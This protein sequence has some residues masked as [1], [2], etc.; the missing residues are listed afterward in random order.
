MRYKLYKELDDLDTVSHVLQGRGIKDID[1][2]LK[3]DFNKINHWT[4]LGEDK[5][6]QAVEMVDNLIQNQQRILV[7]V[8]C[9][10][11]GYTSAAMF[12]NYI[13]EINKSYAKENIDFF[14]HG[15]KEH[16]LK[17]LLDNRTDLEQ[18]A[19]I[20]VPDAGSNDFEE[21]EFLNNK[22]I[23]V[24]ILD[25]HECSE[26]K[27]ISKYENIIF[28]NNQTCDYPNKDFS[29][30]GIVWQF[31]RA[32]DEIKGYN[33]SQQFLDLCAIA[34]LGDMMDYRSLETRMVILA[35]LRS[36][37]N[38]FLLYMELKNHFSMEKMGGTNYLSCAFYIVPFIN[39]TVRSGTQEEKEMI[40]KSFLTLYAFEKIPSNKRGHKGEMVP[41]VEEAVRVCGNIK[42]RQ[43]KLQDEGMKRLE[44]YIASDNMLNNS[45][46]VFTCEPGEVEKSIAGLVANKLMS[47]YQRPCFVLTKSKSKNDKEYYYRG[48]ARNYSLSE[49]EDLRQDCLNSGLVEYAAGHASAFGISVAEKDINNFVDYFNKCYNVDS[50]PVYWVDYIWNMESIDKQAIL[51]IADMQFCWGQEIQESMVAV[52]NID[53]SQCNIKLLSP[54]KHPT[55]KISLQDGVDFIKFNSSEEEYESFLESSQYL[56]IVGKCKKNEW[57]NIIT[58]QIQIEDY[59]LEH[60][61]VF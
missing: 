13:A 22:G 34:N 9:D 43:T 47:K 17:D 37:S 18:Y 50:E 58:P 14:L 32:F 23:K 6:R 12:I 42:S 52:E 56:T 54:D 4:A 16:G 49:I 7:L 33:Y 5:M 10:C 20:I 2:W 40:F 61:W 60:V 31:C 46:L 3:L 19:A 39:A 25:H 38:P 55:L 36:I 1:A 24:L 44:E 30:G 11:D 26:Y 53:L 59:E 35:G 28:I 29:G 45:A 8:D 27:I 51:A 48:S 57:C 41:L 21:Q 15:G